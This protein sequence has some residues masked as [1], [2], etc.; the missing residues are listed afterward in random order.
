MQSVTPENGAA[1]SHEAPEDATLNHL[2]KWVR[3]EQITTLQKY[4]F[5]FPFEDF[6]R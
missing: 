1:R 5:L 4:N 2:E 6:P 3:E